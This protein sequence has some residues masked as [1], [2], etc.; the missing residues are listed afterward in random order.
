[1]CLQIY[2]YKYI[3]IYIHTISMLYVL[4][5]VQLKTRSQ[6]IELLLKKYKSMYVY[7]CKT[8]RDTVYL[9]HKYMLFSLI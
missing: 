7:R 3:H 9:C 2:I 5:P 8:Y 6:N 1:M 4:A